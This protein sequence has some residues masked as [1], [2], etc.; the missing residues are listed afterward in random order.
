VRTP[1]QQFRAPKIGRRLAATASLAAFAVAGAAVGLSSPAFA[2][3]PEITGDGAG[4]AAVQAVSPV[5][6]LA[7]DHASVTVKGLVTFTTTE[8]TA[9]GAV[10]PSQPATFEVHTVSGWK[11]VTTK[12]LSAAGTATF[13]FHPNYTHAYRVS[14]PALQPNGVTTYHE[15]VT[16]SVTVAAKPADIGP[17]IVALAAKQK[18][19]PYVFGAAGPRSFD[20]SGLVKYVMAHFGVRLPHQANEQ[21]RYGVRVSAANAKPGDL[22]FV[23]EGSYASHV[24]IYAG[25]GLWWEAPHTGASVRH[26]KIWSNNVE[27][28]RLR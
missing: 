19:K 13:T 21:K 16:A 2:S 8:R 15:A 10:V 7:A 22:V 11:H 5:V 25:H 23:L 14:F 26:V 20:C 4:G 24:A 3:V 27:F 17:A 1:N 18:G 28:R 12:T 9:A 6:K